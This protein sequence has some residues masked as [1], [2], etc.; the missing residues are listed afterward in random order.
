M[1]EAYCFFSVSQSTLLVAGG[2][3]IGV[4]TFDIS[5]CL[6]SKFPIFISG[7]GSILGSGVMITGGGVITGFTITGVGVITGCLYTCPC[8]R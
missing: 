5:S 8:W 3:T 2:G 6:T 1:F 4:S 7:T